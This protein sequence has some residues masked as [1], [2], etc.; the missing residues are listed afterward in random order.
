MKTLFLVRHAKS[1]W[2]YPELDDFERPLNRRGRESLESMGELLK[3]IKAA[4]DLII[5]SPATR[6]ATTARAIADMI[7]Y[8]LENIL[9]SESIYMSDAD[10]LLHF[11]QDIDDDVKEAML[12]GHNP[13]LTEL[14][15]YIS[16][17]Q[18][19]NIP[20]C[21]IFCVEFNIPSWRKI[22]ERCGI[23]KFFEFP[24]RRES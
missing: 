15:N 12:I 9:Y 13:A 8:S 7:N 14:G 10:I 22:G 18:I 19:S 5:S 16:N 23:L 1:S 20:T 21:G 2:K 4:P 17:K 11:I 6:A 3:E 24:G